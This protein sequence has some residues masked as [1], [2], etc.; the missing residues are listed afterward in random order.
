MASNQLQLSGERPVSPVSPPTQ[1]IKLYSFINKGFFFDETFFLTKS[2]VT[3]IHLLL[4]IGA[5]SLRKGAN[6]KSAGASRL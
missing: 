3:H 4:E 5:G 1:L 2:D 6:F